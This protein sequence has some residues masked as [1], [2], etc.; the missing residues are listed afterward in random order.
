MPSLDPK[1]QMFSS[2]TFSCT[3]HPG[4]RESYLSWGWQA[5]AAA[6]VCPKTQRKIG[7]NWK[8]PSKKTKK[9][10]LQKV[11]IFHVNLDKPFRVCQSSRL[12]GLWHRENL[13]DT[14]V[15]PSR[16]SAELEETASWR[17]DAEGSCSPGS[18][19]TDSS[20]SRDRQRLN[21]PQIFHLIKNID[22]EAN[23]GENNSVF[24]F[25]IE[26]GSDISKTNSM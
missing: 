13:S 10:Q 22:G 11:I 21:T 25:F 23:I 1:R 20:G 12:E 15:L 16:G 9:K 4:R 3:H 2:R 14:A 19:E 6:S 18:S 24:V 17:T 7:I 8:R 5:D 26:P